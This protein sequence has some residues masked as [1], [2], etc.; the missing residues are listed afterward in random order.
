MKYIVCK[1]ESAKWI[2]DKMINNIPIQHLDK[3]FGL[4]FVV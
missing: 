4:Y 2:L 3:D 1:K